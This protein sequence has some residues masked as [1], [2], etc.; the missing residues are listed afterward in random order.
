MMAM[1]R[2]VPIA[3]ALTLA[4]GAFPAAAKHRSHDRPEAKLVRLAH[5][6]HEATSEVRHR[7]FESRRHR[8]FRHW[9]AV[10]ALRNLDRDARRFHRTVEREGPYDRDTRWAYQRLEHSYGTAQHS[11][12]RLRG[13]RRLHGDFARVE[14]LMHRIDSRLAR[15]D[16]RH[17]RNDHRRHSR[18]DRWRYGDRNDDGHGRWHVSWAFDF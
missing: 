6:L 14:R 17:R 3:V 7:A 5:E 10:F 15:Y 13:K 18:H 4:L 9:R 11:F 2:L 16:G 8:G 1:K 12:P